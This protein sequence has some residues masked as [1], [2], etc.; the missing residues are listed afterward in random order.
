MPLIVTLAIITAALAPAFGWVADHCHAGGHQHAHPHICGHHETGLPALS[1]LLLAGA[2]AL[3]TLV[4]AA[5]TAKLLTSSWRVLEL[6][7]ASSERDDLHAVCILPL[8]QPQAFVMGVFRPRIFVT[9][10]LLALGPAYTNAVLAHE[11]A[12]LRRADGL[13]RL[14]ATLAS[15]LHLPGVARSLERRLAHTQEMAA[16]EEAATEL[17][18]RTALADALVAISRKNLGAARGGTPAMATAFTGSN[19]AGSNV[20]ARVQALLA[21]PSD[22]DDPSPRKLLLTLAAGLVVVAWSADA[23]HHGVEIALGLVGG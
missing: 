20:E 21:T 5:R 15:T 2:L 22:I 14:V 7:G 19:L 18:S 8:A 13:R 23:I 10:G 3:R 17:G 16:D 1:I 12:H 11:R 6:A 9:R 4:S